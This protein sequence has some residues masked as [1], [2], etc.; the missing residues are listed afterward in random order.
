[1]NPYE[2]L[3]T[4]DSQT[5]RVSRRWQL[6]I[7]ALFCILGVAIT[8]AGLLP[9]LA[10]IMLALILIVIVIAAGVSSYGNRP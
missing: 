10:V 2:P 3:E 5:T 7:G 4:N 1:M 8:A 9:V 6:V